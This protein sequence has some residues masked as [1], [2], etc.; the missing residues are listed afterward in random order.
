MLSHKTSLITAGTLMVGVTPL[1]GSPP[2]SASEAQSTNPI[3]RMARI[4]NPQ[5]TELEQRID[6]LNDR[7]RSMA[8]FSPKPVREELGW[9]AMQA[10]GGDKP[11]LTLDLGEVYPLSD[12]YV[13]PALPPF[14][15]TRRLFPLK[16]TLDTARS[17][18]FA[19]ARK[20]YSTPANTNESQDGYPLRVNT[21][22]LDARYVRLTVDTGYSRGDYS[23]SMISELMVLSG[24]QPVSLTATATATGSMNSGFDWSPK[25]A[26]DGQSPLGI[27]QSGPWN[28]SRGQLIKLANSSDV[29]TWQFDLGQSEPLDRATLFPY[30]LPEIGGTSALPS[31]IKVAVSDTPE[32]AEDSFVSCTG[33]ETFSPSTLP[34]RGKTGR[35]VTISG[36]LFPLTL[37]RD[38]IMAVSEIEIW[39]LG[40][41]LVSGSTPKVLVNGNPASPS[42]ELTDG[43]ANGHEIIPVGDWLRQIHER[44]GIEEELASLIPK[45]NNLVSEAEIN[46]TW[47]ASVAIGLTFLIPVAIFERRRLVS[48]KQ[49]DQLRRRIASD[50]HDDIGSNLGSIS[51][52]AR[53]AKK[54]L[55]RI[56]DPDTLAE[57]LAEME[58]IA[59][60]SSLAMRDIV[61]L[62][63]R[64]QDSIGDFV[65]RMRSTADRLLREMEFEM[66]CKSNRTALKLTLEAKRHLFLF[67]KEA[68]HNILKHSKAHNVRVN[69]F[70]DRD[71]LIMEVTDDG[72][73]LPVDEAGKAAAVKKLTARA[74]VL[75]GRFDVESA[76]GQGTRLR[77]EVKRAN[78][79]ATKAA[80]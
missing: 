7:V 18:D 56:H 34:L 63:E 74:A 50:L 4:I 66:T 14:G 60:E 75:E 62:L 38:N 30:E 25:Y 23:I 16:L 70:D 13:I 40:R 55:E 49:I 42:P 6:A 53:S 15:E 57:D 67:Y 19:D 45:R 69:I 41:N 39:S 5:L 52:I 20:V 59:R 8:P 76:P 31:I 33:G 65:E 21:R 28:T 72:I 1:L 78:L 64:N 77:L 68:L 80:A 36:S 79:I 54:D 71:S 11:T 24:G 2:L 48:R 22:D 3:S 44:Q 51:L 9:R 29:V 58:T 35:Y 37:G 27:W 12:I 17:A 47:G 46:A 10:Q 32:P 43:R 26:I 73:G 61:W